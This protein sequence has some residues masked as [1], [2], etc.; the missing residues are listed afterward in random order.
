[1]AGYTKLGSDFY[2]SGDTPQDGGYLQVTDPQTLKSL[3][4]GQ[5]PYKVEAV[6]RPLTFA[7]QP[8]LGSGNSQ[9]S[10]YF[11]QGNTQNLN[12]G[13]TETPASTSL[14]GGQ[15]INSMF[16]S[17]FMEVMNGLTSSK[18]PALQARQRQIQSQ[19]MNAPM[20]DT[21][22]MN[23][24]SILQAVGNRGQ[25]YAGALEQATQAISQEKSYGNDALQTLSALSSLAKNLGPAEE[26]TTSDLTEYHYAQQ[27]GYSGNFQTWLKQQA[28]L[29]NIAANGSGLDNQTLT[30]V[31]QVANAF[32][33]QPIVKQFNEVQNKV[34]SMQRII[35]SGVGGPGDLALVYEFMKALDP[36]ST[37]RESEYDSAAKSGNIFAGVMAKFNGYFKETGG[38]LPENV[39]SAF[40]SIMQT[41]FGVAQSQYNN[42][43]NEFGRRINKLTN[44]KD[45]TDYLTNYGAVTNTLQNK[46]TSVGT[47]GGTIR[48]KLNSSGQTGTIPETEFDPSLYT[49]I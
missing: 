45:G 27:E 32:D 31:Q 28:N 38:S 41:K 35:D 14:T 44:G 43:Y 2:Y 48:V 10:P 3:K 7:D 4:A 46:P 16:K 1:M 34:G 40:V 13:G 33:S 22:N 37:V 49:K 12:A 15:D 47:T 11:K 29:K 5:I 18:L 39:K 17:K 19:Q 21:T 23:P 20:P 24:N 42:L 36:T 26:K 8:S 30:K 6:T 25:E 9:P